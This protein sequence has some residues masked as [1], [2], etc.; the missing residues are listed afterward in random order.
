MRVTGYVT[1][2]SS[3]DPHKTQAGPFYGIQSLVFSRLIAYQNQ[4]DGAIVADLLTQILGIASIALLAPAA[5]LGWRLVVDHGFD[6]PKS[7]IAFWLSGALSAAAAG[8]GTR[9]VADALGRGTYGRASGTWRSYVSTD[10]AA[11]PP[12]MQPAIDL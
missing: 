6:R 1:R 5:L 9:P 8:H 2:D 3:L 12:A 4:V 11:A 10:H 7:R